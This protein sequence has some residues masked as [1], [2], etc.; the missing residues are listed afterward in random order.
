MSRSRIAGPYKIV[1]CIVRFVSS[2]W[3]HLELRG[4]LLKWGT[5][6][7]IPGFKTVQTKNHFCMR[8]TPQKQTWIQGRPNGLSS[9]L[10]VFQIRHFCLHT[11]PLR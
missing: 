10:L 3:N 11:N 6:M 4:F 9:G 2:C 5:K 1:S 8:I 7:A